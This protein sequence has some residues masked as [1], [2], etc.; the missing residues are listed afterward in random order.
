MLLFILSSG[1]GNV[2]PGVEFNFYV[3]PEA[4]FIVFD[5]VNATDNGMNPIV[6][7]PWESVVKRNVIPM[8]STKVTSMYRLYLHSEIIYGAFLRARILRVTVW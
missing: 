1:I 5:S 7:F 6:L 3:D 4:D 8:V 2:M